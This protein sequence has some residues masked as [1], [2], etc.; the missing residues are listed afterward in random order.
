MKEFPSGRL[1][2][3]I[4]ICKDGGLTNLLGSL[5][6]LVESSLPPIVK[7]NQAAIREQPC[8]SLRFCG[9]DRGIRTP[10]RAR[11]IQGRGKRGGSKE[12][13]RKFSSGRRLGA[14]KRRQGQRT[15]APLPLGDCV[16]KLRARRRSGNRSGAAP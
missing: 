5:R 2:H 1:T 14:A 7:Q 6:L 9:A 12:K 4:S 3:C 11:F 15:Q 13:G 16:S 8:F 10:R